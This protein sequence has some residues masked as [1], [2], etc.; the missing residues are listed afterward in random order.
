[1]RTAGGR[2]A[3]VERDG[4]RPGPGA[5]GPAA[6]RGLGAACRPI[7]R[8]ASARSEVPPGQCGPGVLCVN[9][10]PGPGRQWGPAGKLVGRLA[11]RG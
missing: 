8:A 4:D 5:R 11:F 3:P 9:S 7:A 10:A 1:L 2:L 6:P